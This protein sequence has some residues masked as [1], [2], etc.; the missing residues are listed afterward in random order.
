MS[1]KPVEQWEAFQDESYYGL[2]AVRPVGENRW[3]YCFHVNTKEEAEGLC[4][5]L[6]K[7]QEKI[8]RLAKLARREHYYCEDSLYV[9]PK[10]PDSPIGRLLASH[11]PGPNCN[12]GADKINAEIDTI[13]A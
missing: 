10:H 7:M 3:G 13:I 8:F 4:N 1:N 9:C 6:N 12:C 11:Y 5:L 2:W